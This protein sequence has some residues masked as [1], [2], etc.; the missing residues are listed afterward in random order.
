MSG[1]RPGVQAGRTAPRSCPPLVLHVE[2]VLDVSARQPVRAEFGFDPGAPLAVR[3]EFGVQGGPCVV[4]RMGRDVLR[5]GLRSRSGLGDAQLWPSDVAGRATVRLQL[6]SG[7]MAALFVLPA[8]PLADWLEHTYELVPEG[9][10]LAGVDWD[11]TTAA[12][13]GGR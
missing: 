5:Q 3:V 2:R 11:D 4:W 9:Q 1:Y 7:D 6:A 12:L 13:L 10:E 8:P